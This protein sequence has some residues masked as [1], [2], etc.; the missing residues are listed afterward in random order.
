ML[1]RLMKS[2]LLI[3]LYYSK[4]ESEKNWMRFISRHVLYMFLKSFI[5]SIPPFRSLLWRMFFC[6]GLSSVVTSSSFHLFEEPPACSSMLTV[7]SLPCQHW[8]RRV[9]IF[10]HPLQHFLFEDFLPMAILIGVRWYLHCSFD[11]N[12]C[13]FSCGEGNG[14][15]LQYSCLENPR[16]WGAWCAAV[17]GITQSR[18]LLKRL[19]SSSRKFQWYRNLSMWLL[20]KSVSKTYLPRLASWPFARFWILFPEST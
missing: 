15:P 17:C 20:W 6:M 8:C 11:L 4:N 14:N 1:L 9:P 5:V 13:K 18:T 12:F 19:S 3:L 10:P 2:H 7:N 16:D